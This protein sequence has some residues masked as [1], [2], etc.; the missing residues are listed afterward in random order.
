MRMTGPHD[1]D[2]DDDDVD[3]DDDDDDEDDGEKNHMDA[4]GS[5]WMLRMMWDSHHV[6]GI[7]VNDDAADQHSSPLPPHPWEQE[8][9][10]HQR[11]DDSL[12]LKTPK[13]REDSIKD[14]PPQG[15][16]IYTLA[17]QKLCF[18]TLVLQTLS[19]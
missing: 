4:D 9:Q 12:T 19:P 2:D 8:G 10:D 1:D 11:N 14:V 17:G 13:C 15:K 16:V 3:D 7:D 18:L 6:G 5:V